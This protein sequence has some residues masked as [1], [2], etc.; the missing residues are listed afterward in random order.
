MKGVSDN[1][2]E[3]N[4]KLSRAMIVTILYRMENEPSASFNKFGDVNADEWYGAAVAW[5]SENG[6]VNGVSE[7]EFAPNDNL[8]REQMAA[9]IYRYIKFK[10]KD[11]SVGENTN[12]LSYTDAENI[13]EYAVEAI[14]YA[15]GSGL[16]KGDSETTLNP[17]GTATRAETA[18][19]IMRLF[20]IME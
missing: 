9:I 20:G 14:C 16:M 3:P 8:T 2:F 19:I 12:I 5:A 13:S 10:G 17:S 11:V 15:V 6:I 4:E 18:T 1:E 7:N